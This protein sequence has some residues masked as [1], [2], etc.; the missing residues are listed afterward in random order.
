MKKIITL[1]IADNAYER[2]NIRKTKK[3]NDQEDVDEKI[4]H[5]LF[6]PHKYDQNY[7]FFFW[8]VFCFFI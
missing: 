4:H 2:E 1:I 3:W 7:A 8:H 6:F 5:V